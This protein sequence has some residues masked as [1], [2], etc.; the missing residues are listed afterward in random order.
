[1]V[2]TIM[3]ALHFCSGAHVSSDFGVAARG[4]LIIQLQQTSV[5]LAHDEGRDFVLQDGE[6]ARS[7]NSVR[8]SITLM[9]NLQVPLRHAS[10]SAAGIRDKVGSSQSLAAAE[11]IEVKDR[12]LEDNVSLHHDTQR[13]QRISLLNFQHREAPCAEHI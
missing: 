5:T 10:N 7:T 13:F 4:S 1:M 11:Y 2:T 9:L 12:H 6:S 8:I 3:N